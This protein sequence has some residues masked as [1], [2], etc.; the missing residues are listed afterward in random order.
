MKYIKL[1]EDLFEE[2]KKREKKRDELQDFCDT[3]LAYLKDE[4][5]NV[6][7]NPMGNRTEITIYLRDF[8]YG[9]NP[10]E[11]NNVKDHIIPFLEILRRNYNTNEEVIFYTKSNKGIVATTKQNIQSVVDDNLLDNRTSIDFKNIIKII[12]N[13]LN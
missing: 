9:G 4:G 3:Y 2:R 5:F 7:V 11:W 13:I 1:F 10:F 12:L 6:Y 8:R